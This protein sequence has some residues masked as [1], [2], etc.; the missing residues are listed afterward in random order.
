MGYRTA[1]SL[2]PRSRFI[3]TGCI[4]GC[5]ANTFPAVGARIAAGAWYGGFFRQS[6]P[7]GG[8]GQFAAGM[9]NPGQWN[10]TF[11]LLAVF[12][13]H[14][15]FVV[16]PA[17]AQAA[18]SRLRYSR[19]D[20]VNHLRQQC[21]DLGQFIATQ[22]P[23]KLRLDND[24]SLFDALARSIIYQQL[25]GKA[26]GTIHGRFC[27]LFEDGK[28]CPAALAE[29]NFDEL[30][31]V[32]LS[33][34]KVL[35]IQDLAE[36]SLAGELPSS[37]KLS[38]MSDEQVIENLVRVR[39]IGPWT[40]Q[41][42]LMFSLGRPDVM[43]ATDLGVQKGVQAVYRMRKLPSPD[44]VLKRTRHLAPY[45]TAASWYFWRAADTVLMT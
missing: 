9:G 12:D 37:R 8:P 6:L 11:D 36:K 18:M 20:A 38:L 5:C 40:A 24:A 32:G 35:A 45:R 22:G 25:S 28:P 15:D 44:Q 30:R 27:S 3:G 23:L 26:A 16:S 39:G 7:Q 34:N 19:V 43:P 42:L 13:R 4:V 29:K 1:D 41:M 21:P 33:R 31:G 2:F 17:S 14:T 10:G